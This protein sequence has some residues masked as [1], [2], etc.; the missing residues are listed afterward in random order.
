M[1]SVN[2]DD[3]IQML[4]FLASV[5]DLVMKVVDAPEW[6]QTLTA[7]QK[8]AWIG[9][10][11]HWQITLQRGRKSVKFMYHAGH[12]MQYAKPT[13]LEVMRMMQ[14]EAW[15]FEDHGKFEDWCANMDYDSTGETDDLKHVRE[16]YHDNRRIARG[17]RRVLGDDYDLFLYGVELS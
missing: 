10:A 15:L 17:V 2:E 6:T 16:V 9:K 12:G 13:L 7:K 8:K 11:A 5:P 1:D 14:D 3:H 4:D